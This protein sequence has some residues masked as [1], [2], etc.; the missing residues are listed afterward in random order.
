MWRRKWLSRQNVGSGIHEGLLL[1]GHEN[2]HHIWWV[3]SRSQD[4]NKR[5]KKF[6]T[7]EFVMKETPI[8]NTHFYYFFLIDLFYFWWC[9]Q[10]IRVGRVKE[11]GKM[12][13]TTAYNFPFCSS[14]IWGRD[15]ERAA[16]NSQTTSV[17][18]DVGR[19]LDVSRVLSVAH[20][21]RVLL[22]WLW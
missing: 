17:P 5:Y 15:E 1:N 7:L 12:D 13:E 14:Y 8:L 9:W 18:K 11:L 2:Y 21:L 22:K 6:C 4:Y 3:C 20:V 10:P 19:L 16:P